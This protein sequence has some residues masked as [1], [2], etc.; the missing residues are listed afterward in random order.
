M[1]LCRSISINASPSSCLDF[2]LNK[3]LSFDR[4]CLYWLY[5]V[6]VRLWMAFALQAF[7]SSHSSSSH[8][9]SSSCVAACRH[10]SNCFVNMS[11]KPSGSGG[12]DSLGSS[13]S[14]SWRC[15]IAFCSRIADLFHVL[16]VLQRYR[17]P[18]LN[19]FEMP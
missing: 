7:F 3:Y 5:A 17:F 4:A 16:Y 15:T 2:F 13:A 9:Y 19:F 8:F 18:I 6:L 11:S 12:T 1:F 14:S 10:F